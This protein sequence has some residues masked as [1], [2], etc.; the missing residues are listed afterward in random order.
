MPAIKTDNS[1]DPFFDPLGVVIIGARHTPGFGFLLPQ[2]L[3]RQGFFDK[4]FLVNPK[5]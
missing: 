3:A 5:G 4:L 1:L 2:A